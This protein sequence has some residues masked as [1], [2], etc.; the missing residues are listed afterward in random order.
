M[1]DR[2][3]LR[4]TNFANC[5]CNQGCP[6]QFGAPTT[7]GFCEAIG[8]YGIEE[9]YFNDTRLDGLNAVQVLYWPGEIAQG[10][11]RTQ[12]LIDERAD[13]KQREALVRIMR[14]DATA[15]GATHFYVFN[16][17]MSEVLDPIYAP[18]ECK[19]DVERRT[20]RIRAGDLLES[21][22]KPIVDPFSG[23]EVRAGIGLPKG[24]EYSYAEVG[25][26]RTRS[27]AAIEL[28]LSDSHAHFSPLHMNQD[29]VIR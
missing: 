10:N 7:N 14:G 24:F 27:R 2:W 17:T 19:I 20:A 12:S 11:G 18:V 22:G 29:G 15:P 6:C 26:G 4:G 21:D 3:M 23:G 16:S 13:A 5:N 28:D 9:G 8:A 1:A 25:I